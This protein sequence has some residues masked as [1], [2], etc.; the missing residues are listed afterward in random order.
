[1]AR[2]IVTAAA[3]V[4]V[5]TLGACA[6]GDGTAY[7]TAAGMTSGAMATPPAI[8]LSVGATTGAT[9]LTR[10]TLTDTLRRN[11]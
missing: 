5:L 11:P 10:D 6:R 8:G 1:M 9:T 3:A 7:D 4:A 2:K